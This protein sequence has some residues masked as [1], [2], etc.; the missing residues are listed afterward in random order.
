MQPSRLTPLAALAAVL[1]LTGCGSSK[2]V[3][4]AAPVPAR[5]AAGTIWLCRPGLANDPCAGSLTDTVFGARSGSHVVRYPRPASP[6]VD[7]FYVYPTV[8]S[9]PTVNARRVAEFAERQVAFAQAARF[10]QDCRVYAPVYRQIT[11]PALAR[12]SR[13]TAASARIAYGDV[14]AAFR[15]YL[16]HFNHGRGIVFI[17][18]SQG[19]AVLTKL[20]RDEVDPRPSLRRRLVSALLLGGDVTV[21]RGSRMGGDFRHIPACAARAETGC[22]VAYSS[23]TRKP[24]ANSDFGRTTSDLGVGLL[25]PRHVAPDTAIMCV[26]PAQLADGTDRLEPFLPTLVLALLPNVRTPTVT[27]PWISLPGELTGRCETSGDATW[28]QVTPIAGSRLPLR[29]VRNPVLGL[30]VVDLNIALGN[31]VR[32]VHAQAAAY[33]SRR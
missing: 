26:N 17:G 3:P 33:V 4:H 12:P 14:L 15:D 18:H 30:H 10:S 21:R 28:L 6:P 9:D 2:P 20:I 25:A 32:L 16:A 22:V 29:R 8:S 19:A 7:C 5:D 23:F 27:T 13:I 24:A 31:L 11:L 1:A